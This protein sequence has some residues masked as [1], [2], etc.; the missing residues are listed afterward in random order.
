MSA[1]RLMC[2]LLATLLIAGSPWLGAIAADEQDARRVMVGINLFPAVLAADQDI[3]DKRNGNEPLLL[4]LVH[5]DEAV[6]VEQLAAVLRDKG[7]VRGIPFKVKSVAVSQLP[8]YAKAKVAGVFVA[9]RM[10]DDLGA[11][12]DF[13]RRQKLLSFSPFAGDVERGVAAGLVVSDRV[14]PYVNT[15][16]VDAAGVRIK[17]FFLKIAERYEQR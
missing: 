5:R 10:G 1:R 17:P 3:G 16:A 6:L 13:S 11:V 8:D 7:A 12:L 2:M 4:L 15:G 9:Q 14:L